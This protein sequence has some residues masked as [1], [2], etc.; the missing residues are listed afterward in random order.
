MA[1]L[2]EW[3]VEGPGTGA[4][5]LGNL[6]VF[7]CPGLG[8]SCLGVVVGGA[9]G[10][11]LAGDDPLPD[12]EE[13][14]LESPELERDRSRCCGVDESCIEFWNIASSKCSDIIW[15]LSIAQLRSAFASSLLVLGDL[16]SLTMVPCRKGSHSAFLRLFSAI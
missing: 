3:L 12:V 2:G 15:A 4:G 9:D 10:P 13:L 7:A 5:G 14:L 1:D 16:T 11:A 6:L 8:P